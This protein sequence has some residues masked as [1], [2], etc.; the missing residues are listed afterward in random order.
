MAEKE[1]WFEPKKFGWGAGKPIH[2]K[3]WALLVAYT[4]LI[5]APVPFLEESDPIIGLGLAS[6]IW[7]PATI[8]LIFIA[9][10]KTRGEWKMR[11]GNRD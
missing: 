1:Y 6:A 10:H 4:L 9:R 3:G 5:L 7:I 8:A 11:I 2:W